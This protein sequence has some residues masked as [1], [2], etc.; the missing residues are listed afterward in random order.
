M[1]Q[2]SITDFFKGTSP[3]D[4]RPSAPSPCVKRPS[5]PAPE[6]TPSPP[7][8][9][10]DLESLCLSCP[11][12]KRSIAPAPQSLPQP[13]AAESEFDLPSFTL[14][15]SIRDAQGRRPDDP[16]YDQSTLWVPVDRKRTPAQEQYWKIKADY[17]DSILFFKL[18]KFYELFY[19]DAIIV[20]RVLE[21]NWMGEKRKCHVGFPERV[22][23]KNSAKLVD[24]GYKV[25]VVEQTET[26]EQLKQRNDASGGKKEKA[27]NRAVTEVY[28]KGTFVDESLQGEQRF[29]AAI[30]QDGDCAACVFTD[31]C[32]SQI[33]LLQCSLKEMYT[34]ISQTQPVEFLYSSSLISPALIRLLKDLPSR[35]V[36]TQL[37][38]VAAWDPSS[39]RL[40][41]P[42]GLPE[43]LAKITEELLLKAVIGTCSYLM[44][45]HIAEKILPFAHWQPYSPALQRYM[46]LD[47]RALD[48]L[49][50]LEVAYGSGTRKEG[51]LLHCLDKTVT[52]YGKRM[53]KRWI[54]M[55]LL[56]VPSIL[57]RQE[58]VQQLYLNQTFIA[59]FEQACRPLQDL[60][61]LL[62]RVAKNSTQQQSNAVYFE[63]IQAKQVREFEIV[64]K[65][66]NLLAQ[67]PMSL[68][69]SSLNSSRIGA[70][71]GHLF[72]DLDPIDREFDGVFRWAGENRVEPGEMRCEEYEEA[73]K[74]EEAIKEELSLYLKQQQ[75][76]LRCAEVAYVDIKYR[77]ELEVPIE[78]VAGKLRPT[79]YELTSARK[80]YERFLTPTIKSLVCRLEKAEEG[81]K[82][83]FKPYLAKTFAQLV[84]YRPL[85]LEAISA[86][87][88]LDCLCALAKAA[89]SYQQDLCAPQFSEN[90]NV[91][92]EANGLRHPVL[93]SKVR[94]FIPNDV[95]LKPDTPTMV[96][97]GPN[98][99]GKSTLLRQ[100][101]V[102]AIL[103]QI[104]AL[105]PAKSLKLSIVDRIFTRMGAKD[106]L[107]L[108]K[109]TFAVE[110]EE[111]A[112]VFHY[113]T[114]KSIVIMDELGR[115]TG[116]SDGAAIA[117]ITLKRILSQFACRMI[118]TT[119]YYML[120]DKISLLP[121]V[122]LSHMSANVGSDEVL[123]LY[124]LASGVCPASFGLN[125][126]RLA[127]VPEGIISRAKVVSAEIERKLRVRR[128]LQAVMLSKHKEEVLRAIE[129]RIIGNS[130]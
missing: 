70:L 67:V 89:R 106:D 121:G 117:Y 26:P 120:M 54:C 92:F 17:N 19:Q 31:C 65:Q 126:A 18:G 57:L 72:P 38:D 68:D 112:E 116:T 91:L 50:V 129:G 76:T 49:E 98:M 47:F 119:H 93:A 48:A 43:D 28:S 59:A 78:A 51:S 15:E 71:I 12:I 30:V 4:K 74:H 101:C 58:A 22:L 29:L 94:D 125:V 55:P 35:P 42:N 84:A 1:R 113:A 83:A 7:L 53:L 105:V 14:P 108:G 115:G 60:E 69:A 2:G 99:G 124:K 6:V 44:R 41:F 52:A 118:F 37:R 73:R 3:S 63:N 32:T 80:G 81:L 103:A 77:Y 109:S 102:A 20:Q 87:A 97:T 114:P 100:V 88:E 107:F 111:A 64:I 39:F 75:I 130:T 45:N 79:D 23:E 86:V 16:A 33:Y 122:Q 62:L 56:H 11:A 10:K 8:R 27:V 9:R 24:L 46:T 21:L 85:I 127:G 123:F 25:V 110:V 36:L 66:I 13:A 61:R 95:V 34:A 104:G 90:E 128:V 40:F 96:L 5:V 82:S